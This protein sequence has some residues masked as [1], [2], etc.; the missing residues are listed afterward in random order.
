[1]KKAGEEVKALTEKEGIPWDT[2]DYVNMPEW[3]PCPAYDKEKKGDFDL[4]LLNY[5]VPQHSMSHTQ[6]NPFLNKLEA[7]HR[8]NWILINRETAEKKGIANGNEIVIEN[9]K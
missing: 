4:Y 3:K 6:S 2:S 1:M 9:T 5:R 7:R 8:D